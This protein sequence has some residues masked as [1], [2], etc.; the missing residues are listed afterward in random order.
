M[1]AY[2]TEKNNLT[3]ASVER[4]ERVCEFFCLH[5]DGRLVCNHSKQ[6]RTSVAV[7]GWR[8]MSK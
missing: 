3:C 5:N 8:K 4:K 1:T 7:S 6:V 2:V